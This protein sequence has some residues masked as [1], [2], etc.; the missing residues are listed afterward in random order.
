ME[1]GDPM[2]PDYIEQMYKEKFGVKVYLRAKV[3][4]KVLNS[5]DREMQGLHK[6]GQL[7]CLYSRGISIFMKEK[8]K[9]GDAMLVEMFLEGKE[10]IKPIKAC[11]GI[12]NCE[13]SEGQKGF[14]ETDAEFLILRDEDKIFLDRFIDEKIRTAV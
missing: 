10:G 4:Y 8:V 1:A 6:L 2:F 12:L 5:D 9:D 7:F 14:F 3:L 11:C 13:E